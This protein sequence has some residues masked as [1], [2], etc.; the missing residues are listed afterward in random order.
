MKKLISILLV[1]VVAIARTEHEEESGETELP[2]E[3]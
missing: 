1:A 3:E 2:Q